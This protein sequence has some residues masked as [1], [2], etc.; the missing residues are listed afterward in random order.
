MIIVTAAS[1]CHLLPGKAK[2]KRYLSHIEPY[3]GQS[4]ELRGC[5]WRKAPE[6]S[7][8]EG[9]AA[10]DTRVGG[11]RQ[12]VEVAGHSRS[13]RRHRGL[14]L[15]LPRLIAGLVVLLVSSGALFPDH[16]VAQGSSDCDYASCALRIR[17][18]SV[19][20]GEAAREVGRYGY[21]SSPDIRPLLQPFDSASYYFRI[22]EDN[23]G[24]GRVRDLVGLVALLFSPFAIGGWESSP[25]EWIGYGMLIGGAGLVW[26]GNR[27]LSAARSAMAD[28]I[29]WYNSAIVSP[30]PSGLAS[31]R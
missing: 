19:L 31:G 23:Y 4:E 2:L 21:F 26:S 25:S 1:V 18:G 10:H 12:P 8:R 17:G 16:G 29:W 15:N 5:E 3:D 30:A 28:A 11:L 7:P 24:S 22:V 27:R 20:A 9:Q 6:P 14:R 13:R